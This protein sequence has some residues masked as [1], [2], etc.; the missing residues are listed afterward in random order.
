MSTPSPRKPEDTV[1]PR[2][3]GKKV[4]RRLDLVKIG[5]KKHRTRRPSKQSDSSL[6]DIP[7]TERGSLES[8][9]SKWDDYD[10]PGKKPSNRSV[11][12]FSTVTTDTV[13]DFSAVLSPIGSELL[14]RR[15]LE[16]QESDFEECYSDLEN[17]SA[18]LSDVEETTGNENTLNPTDPSGLQTHLNLRSPRGALIPPGS[19]NPQGPLSAQGLHIEC[20][21]QPLR[22]PQPVGPQPLRVPQPVGLQSLRS[23]QPSCG[24]QP[25]RGPHSS[26]STHTLSVPPSAHRQHSSRSPH[27]RHS[28]QGPHSP[29]SPNSPQSLLS[30]HS[31]QS[32]LSPHSP[33]SLLSSHSP[34]NLP[35][36]PNPTDPGTNLQN[37]RALK[38]Q[39]NLSTVNG[40]ENIPSNTKMAESGRE[41]MSYR[42]QIRKANMLLVDDFKSFEIE[43]VTVEF[44]KQ[45]CK[46]AEDQKVI[47]QNAMLHLEEHDAENFEEHL[48]VMATDCKRELIS[49]IAMS[50]KAIKE[51]ETNRAQGSPSELIAKAAVEAKGK[52]VNKFYRA[53]KGELSHIQEEMELLPDTSTSTDADLHILT[54]NLQKLEKN[55]EQLVIEIKELISDALESGLSEA[56]ESLESTVRAY[57][58]VFREVDAKITALR[59]KAGVTTVGGQKASGVDLKA[60][61][62][63][64]DSA[65][66]IDFYS[67]Q[68]DWNEYAAAKNL[69]KHDEL[70][71]L[72]KT[73]LQGPAK[74]ACQEMKTIEDVWRFLKESYGDPTM[75]FHNKI[76]E[77]KKLGSC[78]GSNVKKRDWAVNVLA[79]LTA[80]HALA[81]KNGIV[82]ELYFSPIIPDISNNL[83]FRLHEDMKNGLR[84]EQSELGILPRKK[85]YDYLIVYLEKLVSKLTFD[86]NYDTTNG[87]QSDSQ[88]KEKSD[89]AK[90][91]KKAYS[92]QEK[93]TN[94]GS[95]GQSNTEPRSVKCRF[96]SNPHTHLY[97]CEKFL[98]AS[99][100][101][102]YGL[103]SKSKTCFRCLRMDSKVDFDD[104][105]TW[106][107]KHKRYCETKF[108]C[109]AGGCAKKEQGSQ[110]HFTMCRY[111]ETE[112]QA[113]EQEFIKS[114][115]ATKLPKNIDVQSLKFFYSSPRIYASKGKSGP[116]TSTFKDGYEI[117]PDIDDPPV[118]LLQNVLVNDNKELLMFYDSGCQGASISNRAYHLLDTETVRPGPTVIDV[119]SGSSITLEHGD[120]Q[121]TLDLEGS[122]KKATL[123]AIRMETI[124]SKFP[125]WEL[126]E[127]WQDLQST[128]QKSNPGKTLPKV[129][130][131]VG[132]CEVDIMVG[133]R[134]NKYFPKLLFTLPGGLG[135]YE[136]VFRSARG[137]QGV[138]GGPH[139]AWKH[140]Q[141]QGLFMNP[142]IYLTYECKSY[143]M[144]ESWVRLNQGKLS[145]LEMPTEEQTLEPVKPLDV[146]CSHQHC[147]EHSTEEFSVPE[148]WSLNFTQYNIREQ[149][150]RFTQVEELGAEIQYRCIACRNCSKCKKGD[151]LEETSLREEM[152][153]ALLESSVK[154]I[155]EKRRL[156]A[157]LPFIEDPQLTLKP[158]RGV[159]EKILESQMKLFAKHPEMRIDT[160]KSHEKLV[161]KGHAIPVNDL[162]P[163]ERE[164]M[165]STPGL[166]Y[167]IPWRTVYKTDSLSTPCRMVFDASARTSSGHSLNSVL[168]KGQ[169]RLARLQDLLIRFRRG[170]VGVTADISMAYNGLKLS[171]SDYKYQ[172]Y[173]WKADL[174]PKNPTVV[175][176]MRTLI[177]GVKSAGGQTQVGLTEL[178]EYCIEHFP[179][180]T[181]GAET[182]RDETYVDDILKSADNLEE[183]KKTCSDITF[184][185]NLGSMTVKDFTISG[186]SPSD[187]VSA[188]GKSVGLAGYIW[189]PMEDIVRL[190][191]KD[192]YLDKVKRGKQP[193]PIQGDLKAALQER[194]TR[195]VLVGKVSQVFDPLGLATPIT[196]NLKLD[197]H[198]VCLTRLDWDDPIPLDYLDSW[199]ANLNEIQDLKQVR[200]KRTLIPEDALNTQVNL[201]V[202]VDASQNI[203]VAC[204]HARVQLKSGNYSTQLIMG[205]SKLVTQ[206]TVPKAELRAAVIGART[207]FIVSKNLDRYF[208][209]AI[210]VTDSTISLYWINQDE[211]P[212]KVGV[213]N[214]V[215]EIRRF[216]DVNQWFH[217]DSHDNIADLGTRRTDVTEITEDS[218]WQKGKPWM[219]LEVE[220][221]PLRTASQVTLS[222]EQKR[223]AA[224]ECKAPDISGH[225]L[226]NLKSRVGDRYAFSKYL[227]DPCKYPWKKS[228]RILGLVNLFIRKLKEHVKQSKEPGFQTPKTE[229]CQKTDPASILP[230][231]A[232]L[233]EAELYYFRKGTKEVKK[234]NK[235]KEYKHC[236][237]LKDDILYYSGRILDDPAKI[238]IE[239]TMLDL[240][241]V[242]FV[243]PILDRYSPLSYAIMIDS[244]NNGVHHRNSIVTLRESLS[245]AYILQGR[246]LAEEIRDA[247]V[248]CRRYKRR[249]LEVEMGKLPDER[250]TIA[251]PFYYTQVDLMGPFEARCEHN[252]RSTVK[253]WGAIFK[254]IGTSAVAVYAM[255]KYDTP[256]FV[257]AYTRFASRYG[258]PSRLYPDEGGQLIKACK[259][260]Q[261][262]ILDAAKELQTKY[263]VGLDHSPCPV[264]GHNVHGAVERS[265]REL[266]KI[267]VCVF[268]G[269]KLDILGYES[270]FAWI[271][272]EINNLPICLGSKYKDLDHQDL[273]T[274]NR[275]LLGRNNDRSL[276][277]F[278]R[279]DKPSRLLEQ[280][281][282]VFDAW[283]RAWKNESLLR[284]IPQP[285]KWNK[286]TYQP[287]QGD[288]VIFTKQDKDQMLGEPVWSTGRIKAVEISAKD[289]L[290]RVVII[291]YRNVQEKT[292]R[293]T[294]RSVRSI[295]VVHKEGVLELI[296][297]LNL[298]A[299]AANQ[300]YMKPNL[301][302]FQQVAVSREAR[303][304]P[305]CR[306]P[307]L[308]DN[309][310]GY[311]ASNPIN[312]T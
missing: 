212:L 185:L 101:E 25:S 12:G 291:E 130:K 65:D 24:S 200:F 77:F 109:S 8:L 81:E 179:E 181:L 100:K 159:A 6:Q 255:P 250:Q 122:K 168:A 47:I 265:I 205:R 240:S 148:K 273:I 171:P 293:T 163:E 164:G 89:S 143:L 287:K 263:S 138:L 26:R 197:L 282:S 97:Y 281:E 261:I 11:S 76:E 247:C 305:D 189:E 66:K 95:Q 4:V 160:L 309:H 13:F 73:A 177:Y 140:A 221:M 153:Q 7:E 1:S 276:S 60:P 113:V 270:A 161:K 300:D 188:D 120:E 80:L 94:Q 71:V 311:F 92:S 72:L 87:T 217:I 58:G 280:M 248:W 162:S 36:L 121:F 304:C 21:P 69:S 151:L 19:C 136:S 275:I 9:E 183:V 17:V 166:G 274:P 237:I 149:Q 286:T 63:R 105:K 306:E 256:T 64:G 88:K 93:R 20:G 123:T 210:Y 44:L 96:C 225:I 85:R 39:Q 29:R 176:I 277:G 156:E 244:H 78:T 104:R 267:F 187:K 150:K 67:F 62:F 288:I 118:F 186:T 152:E 302:I 227:L 59:K 222:G 86:I 180:H 134:Y 220:E 219:R 158:N 172:Q 268:G 16:E 32:L 142:R 91:G 278:C 125:V 103:T 46:L 54:S 126:Q 84:L 155:P 45:R 31:P 137:C 133:I 204:V 245:K 144:E 299:G 55:G 211:R 27:R 5:P 15:Y 114:L 124:T 269:I 228:I 230:E 252:H 22:G 239:N 74:L 28:S 82:D 79:K 40:V 198:T 195:R 290:V 272:N 238:A 52:R 98:K 249:L 61:E 110:V 257:Q 51:A 157:T 3:S 23:L 43:E 196:A 154:L 135:I 102:R 167:V 37:P 234:F 117:L 203:A 38:N 303:R 254:D 132:G 184:T 279:L 218:E 259:E 207:G 48:K 289:G 193:K 215:I 75:I 111:H 242:S 251:P 129:D 236:S 224:V 285:N 169:N 199:V 35:N 70:K 56:A 296:Q 232:D 115:D 194:F 312:L 14:D 112:N 231:D 174:D 308:C 214:A 246:S 233:Q 284:F 30:P 141:D 170:K 49:F 206:S 116:S 10:T 208:G 235:E 202:S 243:K 260:M 146:K 90:Q 283:W 201:V 33:Q 190:N 131:S 178:A 307:V 301:N 42:R 292:L 57:R 209:S 50:Q 271:S 99:V 68:K 108:P 229:L 295:A 223:A 147:E 192:I 310:L 139:H 2:K 253:V 173:L 83:P 297:E 294:R 258:H 34:Q 213:R 18:P 145:L 241:P 266:K 182:L 165:E 128:Y 106:F 119:C 53:L 127:A 41:N 216:T 226:S 264:G 298:A 175:M 107:F 191:I 262:N